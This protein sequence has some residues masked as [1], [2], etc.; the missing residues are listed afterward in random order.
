MVLELVFFLVLIAPVFLWMYS[1]Y[2]SA[3]PKHF[4]KPGTWLHKKAQANLR[5]LEQKYHPSWWCPFGTTQTVKIIF[6]REIVE[7]EDGGAAGIDWLIPEGTDDTT[8]IVIFLPGIT[9]STH[10]SSYVLHPVM[11]ARD[12]GW[13]CL[14]VNPRGLGGVKLR[15]TRTYNA[16]LP[17][18]FAFI[19]K[20][21]H[22]R[23][24]EAR[25]LG[26]G[27][28]MGGMILWNY[29][30][31]MGEDVHLD[32]GM[33]VSSPWDPMVASD[34]IECFIPQTIFNRFIAKSLVD[35]VRPYR[36]LFKDMVDF[37]AVLKCNTVRGF[38]KAFVTPMYGFESY[39][40][41][42]KMATLATK[43]DKIKI[44]CV[45][46]NSVD[47]YFS[48]VQ[49]IPINDIAESEN[50]LG[51]ITNHGGHTAFMESADPN[52]RGMV[53]K[54]LSQWGNLVFHDYH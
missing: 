36:E 30:A 14:V 43:V 2:I 1:W 41:Y 10:D 33:I 27:F 4:V 20:M 50:V 16:A 53:E 5:V 31:M 12:K 23:Y 46:L 51:I 38:D 39:E 3:V 11:E 7:F 21:V 45:T 6:S 15:T 22:E 17:H 13:K 24:P 28:S 48:P 54:L 26:C 19:A 25:K 40:A 9:G 18:D 35:I 37:D 44:P 42:Y 34:S 8:P 52:A 49:C 29:L 47:D 32:A